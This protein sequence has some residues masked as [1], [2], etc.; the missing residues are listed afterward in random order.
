MA[1]RDWLARLG[2]RRID[3]RLAGSGLLGAALLALLGETEPAEARRRGKAKSKKRSR[4][5]QSVQER[6]RRTPRFCGGI[7]GIPCPDDFTCIDDPGDDCDPKQGGADCGGICV[8]D[9]KTPRFCGGI[10]GIPCP[11]GFTCVDDPGDDCDP[12]KGGADCGGICVRRIKDVCATVRCRR[13]THCCPDCGRVCIPDTVSCKEACPG[14]FCGG[15]AGIPCPDGFT[16]IDDPRDDCDPKRGGAD[17]GG[18]CVRKGGEPC[19]RTRCGRGEYCCNPSCGVCAPEGGACAAIVCEPEPGG[20][21][22]GTTICPRGQVCCN[23][24]CGICTPPDGA[25]IMIACVEEIAE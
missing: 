23:A 2:S 8:R 3:R 7:A 1:P 4:R 18:I 15:I 16:C 13:G 25:C 10:A 5:A 6:N 20:E 21:R 19:G 9:Q 12:R 14:T 17:C 11:D 22:C 24:S